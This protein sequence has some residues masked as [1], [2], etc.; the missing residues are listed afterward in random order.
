VRLKVRTTL[1]GQPVAADVE[2]DLAGRTIRNRANVR[3]VAIFEDLPRLAA[4]EAR[5][6]F[7]DHSVAV[8]L[9]TLSG[10][11][12]TM[13][14]DFAT[15]LSVAL[16]DEAVEVTNHGADD[17]DAVLTVT[18]VGTSARTH[19]TTL[20]IAAGAIATYRL[21]GTQGFV[22]ATAVGPYTETFAENHR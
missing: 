1:R 16:T 20:S 15:T 8:P 6:R 3:G 2:I 13:L 4:G 22:N 11:T 9:A 21:E 17:V 14:I 5:M 12:Q 19:R 7:G 10:G 18:E